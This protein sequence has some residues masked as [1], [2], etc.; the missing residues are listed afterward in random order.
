[1]NDERAPVPP[2]QERLAVAWNI[3]RSQHWPDSEVGRLSSDETW[4]AGPADQLVNAI[5]AALRS[6][7]VVPP[8][9]EACVQIVDERW[10]Y[11]PE[12]I[13]AANRARPAP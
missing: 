8:D 7:A 4:F 3:L 10:S 11:A 12:T 13:A 2:D 5:A 9:R 1:M 6:P